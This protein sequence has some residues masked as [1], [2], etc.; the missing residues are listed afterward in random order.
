M[1]TLATLVQVI[2]LTACFAAYV[3]MAGETQLAGMRRAIQIA[4]GALSH[5][6]LM[7][8]AAMVEASAG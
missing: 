1:K 2:A 4:A 5:A 7:T 6:T 3:S 8:Q